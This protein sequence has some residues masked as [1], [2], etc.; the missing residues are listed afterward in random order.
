MRAACI[1]E[2]TERISEPLLAPP[3]IRV[4]EQH[5]SVSLESTTRPAS[6]LRGTP[7]YWS[8]WLPDSGPVA[9]GFF[10]S[11]IHLQS[12]Q[13][14]RVSVALTGEDNP[15]KS[16]TFIVSP[17]L[18]SMVQPMNSPFRSRALSYLVA[19]AALVIGGSV[20][21]STATALP[22]GSGY[23]GDSFPRFPKDTFKYFVA[24]KNLRKAARKSASTWNRADVGYRFAEVRV[25]KLSDLVVTSYAGGG[26]CQG[27]AS[28]GAWMSLIEANIDGCTRRI[29]QAVMNHEFGHVLGLGHDRKKCQLMH[30][31]ASSC[32]TLKPG[33]RAV[34]KVR[35]FA[36]H[37]DRLRKAAPPK[38]ML[39]FRA[40]RYTTPKRTYLTVVM[41][42]TGSLSRSTWTSARMKI[43]S[44]G[45]KS[46]RCQL[47][48]YE[49][50]LGP[51]SLGMESWKWELEP[52]AAIV[53]SGSGP[54]Q[55][56]G[57]A[58]SDDGR[59][60]STTKTLKGFSS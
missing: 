54:V 55:V 41:S 9:P 58:T 15:S 47:L 28:G 14:N 20:V 25:R 46:T 7:G 40:S 51:F 1:S 52:C 39:S 12:V 18:L 26:S 3:N 42:I 56:T 6:S 13:L 37:R 35:K 29:G 48:D 5:P 10:I 27:Y 21:T 34:R 53:A 43:K 23:Y 60:M 2:A 36:R 16:S 8:G 31:Y 57:T 38:P 44:A 11:N 22:I 45:S 50:G 4:P 24:K 19:I 33:P 32:S 30:P 49:I 59:T 17:I